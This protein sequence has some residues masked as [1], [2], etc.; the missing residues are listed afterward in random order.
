[1]SV[2]EFDLARYDQT[3]RDAK[4]PAA[5]SMDELP[6]GTYRFTIER[7]E[8]KRTKESNKPM[9]SFGLMVAEGGYANRWAWKN[10]VLTA[11][12]EKM[13]WIRHELKIVGVQCAKAS[14]LVREIP[15]T[16]GLS[17]WAK[18]KTRSKDGNTYQNVN[19]ISPPAGEAPLSAPGARPNT[20]NNDDL[21]DILF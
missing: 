11:D 7:A 17:V 3:W 5:G 14:D 20:S 13:G 16:I 10:L 2:D 6:D 9:V 1:M 18:L 12:P 4:E 19:F 15:Q 21:D 8:L